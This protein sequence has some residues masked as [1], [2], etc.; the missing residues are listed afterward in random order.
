[1]LCQ[2]QQLYSTETLHFPGHPRT[3]VV[4]NKVIKETNRIITLEKPSL[5]SLTF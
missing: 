4:L 3:A 1:M 2:A 5:P